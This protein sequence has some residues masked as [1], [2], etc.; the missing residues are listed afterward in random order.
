MLENYKKLW[1]TVRKEISKISGIEEVKIFDLKDLVK[2][3][4]KSDDKVPLSRIMNIP[5]CVIIIKYLF[6]LFYLNNY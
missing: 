2:C 1:Y 6:K 3:R 5:K 4:F